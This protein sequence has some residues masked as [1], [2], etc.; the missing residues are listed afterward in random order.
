MSSIKEQELNNE[1]FKAANAKLTEVLSA[2]TRKKDIKTTIPISTP[3]IAS[4]DLKR[5]FRGKPQIVTLPI[6]KS[7]SG[8]SGT[9]SPPPP[10]GPVGPN[11]SAEDSGNSYLA[12]TTSELGIYG[13]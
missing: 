10:A 11:V 5:P 4:R 12:Y 6:I 13:S 2:Y 9:T 7:G 3:S 1:S 8:Q